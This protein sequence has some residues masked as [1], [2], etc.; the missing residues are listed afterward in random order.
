[1][2]LNAAV[3]CH[4]INDIRPATKLHMAEMLAYQL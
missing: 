1:M 2:N 3:L 4:G